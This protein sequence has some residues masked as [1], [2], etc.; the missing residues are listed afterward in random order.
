MGQAVAK[1]STDGQNLI[2][3]EETAIFSSC[4]FA[5]FNQDKLNDHALY[6]LVFY[7]R[8]NC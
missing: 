3:L 4:K 5:V 1:L 2:L 7:F 8:D 6:A